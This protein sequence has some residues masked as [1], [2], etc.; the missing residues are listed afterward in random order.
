[1]QLKNKKIIYREYG[2]VVLLYSNRQYII[3]E[4]VLADF[5]RA[6]Y[7][8]KKS[9]AQT[10]KI[11]CQ[12]YDVVDCQQVELDLSNFCC[13]LNKISSN[14]SNSSNIPYD[15]HM[16]NQQNIFDFMA[17][18]LIPFSATIEITDE[19]NFSCVHCYRGKRLS[20]FW[21]VES[22][23]QLLGDLRKMGTLHLTFTGG[24]PFSHPQIKEFIKLATE[25]DFVVTIQ[26]NA[27]YIT[28]KLAQ[29]LSTQNIQEVDVSLY[30]TDDSINDKIT[31]RKNS[32]KMT[33][34]GIELLCQ[35]GIAVSI[36]CPVLT[37]NQC[38]LK[39]IQ[40]FAH[41]KE[42]G[43]HFAP[44]IIPSQNHR[45]TELLNVFSE[46]LLFNWL[47]DS[48]LNLYKDRLSNIRRARPKERYCQT[49]FRSIT[50]SAQGDLLICNAFRLKCGSLK[51]NNV[52]ELWYSALELHKWRNEYSLVC[53][54]CKKCSDY[55][56]CE[57]CPAHAYTLNHNIYEIDNIT[58]CF[59]HAFAAA[60]RKH[61]R[62]QIEGGEKD[63]DIQKEGF[64]KETV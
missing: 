24:E 3:L 38:S 48:D 43:V 14:Y 20:S 27:S 29:W 53:D 60:D 56:Y 52:K 55:G 50:L 10:K 9:F 17:D 19:C 57:P 33:M 61:Q 51:T 42:I 26:T 59:G 37:F 45:H 49:G 62:K 2:E 5:F 28:P 63:E 1:M 39:D 41:S 13:F 54:K 31:G 22:M 23:S 21:K 25:L 32:A 4:S 58:C 16:P 30:S 44:K 47:E 34:R 36:N 46:D 7:I 40:K 12:L 35:Y 64:C 15:V 11:I 6:I 18:N 8:E